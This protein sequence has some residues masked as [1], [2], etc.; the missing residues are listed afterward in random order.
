MHTRTHTLTYSPNFTQTYIC[1]YI[2]IYLYKYIHT[3]CINST[4]IH[5]CAHTQQDKTKLNK[6][7]GHRIVDLTLT[8]KCWFVRVIRMFWPNFERDL[9]EE[10]SRCEKFI[11]TWCVCMYLI[12]VVQ[13]QNPIRSFFFG[14]WIHT[15]SAPITS[16]THT[17]GGVTIR[18]LG[19]DWLLGTP[20]VDHGMNGNRIK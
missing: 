9:V 3:A 12:V 5:I 15:V 4:W 14:F 1:K 2:H 16:G 19:S 7:K 18:K 11:I 8:Q 17:D 13:P 10:V 20:A 6:A